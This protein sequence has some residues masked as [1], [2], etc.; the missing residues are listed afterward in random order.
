M[1]NVIVDGVDGLG[2]AG[3]AKAGMVRDDHL[4]SGG[5]LASQLKAGER[6]G[7]V[8]EDKLGSAADGIDDRPDAIDVDSARAKP[9]RSEQGLTMSGM[10]EVSG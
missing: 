10:V 3:T 5:Q 1:K 6:A 7:A 8:Q 9:V 2:V 4:A